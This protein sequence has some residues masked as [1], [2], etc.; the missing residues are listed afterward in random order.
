MH[1]PATIILRASAELEARK[2]K[3]NL[4]S[5]AS[6]YRTA[7]LGYLLIAHRQTRRPEALTEP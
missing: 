2:K 1:I 7:A 5:I 4:W 3:R 6:F